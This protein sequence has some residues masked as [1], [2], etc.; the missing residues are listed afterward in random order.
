MSG[1]LTWLKRRASGRP[2]PPLVTAPTTLMSPPCAGV[3]EGPLEASTGATLEAGGAV[4]AACVG[5][6][7]VGALQALVGLHRRTRP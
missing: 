6:A 2:R 5:R 3:A 1:P 4:G 7:A